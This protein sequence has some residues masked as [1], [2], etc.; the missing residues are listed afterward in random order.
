MLLRL[1]GFKLILEKE[2]DKGRIDAVLE[3]PDKIYVLEFKFAPDKR[4]KNP[5]ILANRA[6]QQIKD[7][8][9]AQPYQGSHRRIVLV[10]IGFINKKIAVQTELL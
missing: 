2:T 1:I 9:Y 4:V 3:L 10:G 6:V 8:G 5:V 7:N